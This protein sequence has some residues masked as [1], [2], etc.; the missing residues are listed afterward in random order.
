MCSFV[1]SQQYSSIGSDNGLA[2]YRQQAIIWANTEPIHWRIYA[3][4]GGDELIENNFDFITKQIV[5]FRIQCVEIVINVVMK[6]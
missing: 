2:P 1:P 3:A 6:T 5:F 4:L